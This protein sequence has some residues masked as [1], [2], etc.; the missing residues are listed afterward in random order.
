MLYILPPLRTQQSAPSSWGN[1]CG[2]GDASGSIEGSSWND[3]KRPPR[4]QLR[5]IQI[6]NKTQDGSPGFD[7]VDTNRNP[8]R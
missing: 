5:N 4:V 8:K 6:V 3:E 7:E 2:T 1:F